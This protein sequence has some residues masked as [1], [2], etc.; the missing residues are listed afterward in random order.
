MKN[1]CDSIFYRQFIH[2]KVRIILC[3]YTHNEKLCVEAWKKKKIGWILPLQRNKNTIGKFLW[4]EV[5]TTA[6]KTH[7]FVTSV[8][9]INKWGKMSHWLSLYQCNVMHFLCAQR[10]I[11]IIFRCLFAWKLHVAQ[12]NEQSMHSVVVFFGL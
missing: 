11:S 5:K 2:S 3:I 8:R 9:R 10:V 12:C 4:C 1:D 7:E 6:W